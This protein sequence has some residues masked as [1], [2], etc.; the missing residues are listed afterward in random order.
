[1]TTWQLNKKALKLEY[2]SYFTLGSLSRVAFIQIIVRVSECEIVMLS[3][4]CLNRD[5]IEP[6]SV[7]HLYIMG[8]CPRFED[9][10]LHLFWF[11][12]I[13]QR[14]HAFLFFFSQ[15]LFSSAPKES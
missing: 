6:Q 10:I 3:V 5:A 11:A 1:M 9:L 15:S 14:Q 2:L 13:V 7:L 4:Q 12:H 8:T